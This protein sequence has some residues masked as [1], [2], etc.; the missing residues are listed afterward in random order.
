MTING[1]SA[2]RSGF[3]RTPQLLH[4]VVRRFLRNRHVVDVAFARAGGRDANQLG[5]ALQLR[6]RRASAVAHAGAQTS[7]QLMD[8]RLRAAFVATRPSMPSGTSLPAALPPSRSNS[9]WK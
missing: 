3:N 1:E 7:H 2:G 6:N 5:L 9:S 8:D 4:P